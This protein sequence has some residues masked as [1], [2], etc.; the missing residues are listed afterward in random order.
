MR[1]KFNVDTATFDEICNAYVASLSIGDCNLGY[2]ILQR[3]AATDGGH[4]SGIFLEYNDADYS[5]YDLVASCRVSRNRVRVD[6]SRPFAGLDR[7][8]GFD[9]GLNIDD[10]SY[11]NFVS[12]LEKIFRGNSRQL[13]HI[14]AEDG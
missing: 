9:I 11:R 12:G 1:V 10:P 2:L 5:G 8:E 14:E 7:V 4:D 13:L 3:A 6:L